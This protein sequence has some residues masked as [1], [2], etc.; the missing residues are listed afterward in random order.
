MAQSGKGS[1]FF[2]ANGGTSWTTF[3]PALLRVSDANEAVVWR[4]TPTGGMN[5]GSP[6]FSVYLLGP[7]HYWSVVN[8]GDG[9][10]GLV[11]KKYDDVPAYIYPHPSNPNVALAAWRDEARRCKIFITSDFGASWSEATD[12]TAP[13]WVKRTDGKIVFVHFDTCAPQSAIVSSTW[14]LSRKTLTQTVS[15]DQFSDLYAVDW[16]G[17]VTSTDD[18]EQVFLASDNASSLLVSRDSTSWMHAF[19][20]HKRNAVYTQFTVYG[21]DDGAIWLNARAANGGTAATVGDLFVTGN[22]SVIFSL[23]LAN[24]VRAASYDGINGYGDFEKLQS[25]DGVFIANKAANAVGGGDL[26]TYVTFDM[27]GRWSRLTAPATRA[28]GSPTNCRKEQGCY[29]NLFGLADEHDTLTDYNGYGR[30][31]SVPSAVGIMFGTGNL[32]AHL[33]LSGQVNTYLSRDAGVTWQEVAA[34]RWAYEIGDHGGLLAIVARDAPT[35]QLSYSWNEG[36]QW[37]VCNFTTELGRIEN[38][39]TE[40]RFASESF[41]LYGTKKNS[42]GLNVGVLY[43]V[44]LK[45]VLPRACQ[46]ADRP[47]QPDSDYETFDVQFESDKCI[48]GMDTIYVRRK[49]DAKCFNPDTHAVDKRSFV[50]CPCT[51]DDFECG[52]CFLR[53][54]NGDCKPFDN[55]DPPSQ[56]DQCFSSCYYFD[57]ASDIKLTLIAGDRCKGPEQFQSFVKAKPCPSSAKCGGSPQPPPTHA[58]TP[59][60][61]TGA[62]TGTDDHPVRDGPSGTTVAIAIAVVLLLVVGGTIAG[63]CFTKKPAALYAVLARCRPGGA[64]GGKGKYAKLNLGD[65]S[66]DTTSFFADDELAHK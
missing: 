29:L 25:V 38:L 11:V 22:D 26:D 30:F 2:T 54:D 34:G 48:L 12:G 63:V 62:L 40:T 14:E 28:D 3:T 1:V 6:L 7:K 61:G 55:C 27:G 9:P 35:N 56:A 51:R 44:D 53:A 18:H 21:V 24:S 33:D 31:Y 20:P 46:G 49:R 66:N 23:S 42:A 65:A 15:R 37:A 10:D 32:G 39:I 5:P 47:N 43:A 4:V 8:G 19:L 41:V 50:Q 59:A 60:T 45:G 52:P 64:A 17:Y 16:T 13:F 36:L 58:G 57:D